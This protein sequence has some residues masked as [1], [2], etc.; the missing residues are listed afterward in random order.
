MYRRYIIAIII[1][2]NKMSSSR[3]KPEPYNEKVS[4]FPGTIM[5]AFF[6]QSVGKPYPIMSAPKPTV[7][8]FEYTADNK[9][10]AT[11]N[12]TKNKICFNFIFF[13]IL[14]TDVIF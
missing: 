10:M 14:Y 6:S 13:F 4:G 3:Y 8:S 7:M 5:V 1:V 2:Q 9:V 11:P 12:I